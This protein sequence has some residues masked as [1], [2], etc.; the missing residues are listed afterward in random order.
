M[1]RK[2]KHIQKIGKSAYKDV[3]GDIKHRTESNKG[4]NIR[5]NGCEQVYPSGEKNKKKNMNHGIE[6]ARKQRD[7]AYT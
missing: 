3:K 7:N 6:I 4:G 2:C 1:N 5:L